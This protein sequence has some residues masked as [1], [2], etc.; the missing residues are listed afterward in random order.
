MHS[1]TR[2]RVCDVVSWLRLGSNAIDSSAS[3][4]AVCDS[5]LVAMEHLEAGNGCHADC[6]LRRR[7]GPVAAVTGEAGSGA[8]AALGGRPRPGFGPYPR[9]GGWGTR[10]RWGVGGAGSGA[11]TARP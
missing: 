7:R 2:V 6:P 11:R 9:A 4:T 5:W 3:P 8:Q 10:P 1:G